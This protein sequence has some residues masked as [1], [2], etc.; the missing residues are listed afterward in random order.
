MSIVTFE[1]VRNNKEVQTY[2]KAGDELLEIIGY[3]KHDFVHALKVADTASYI[4]SELGHDERNIELAKIASYIHDIGNMINRS[5][6]SQ[7]GAVL[8]FHVLRD[9]GMPPEEL[10]IVL[11]AIGNHDEG[12]GS[13]VNI[14]SAALIIADKADVRRSRVRNEDLAT[15]DIHDRVNYAVEKSEVKV[16]V[17]NNIILLDLTIDTKICSL[18]EYFEIFLHRMMLCR[19]A[20][21]FLNY[22]FELDMNGMK[23]L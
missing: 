20:A 18:M 23:I 6:H 11:S 3:T 12:T 5:D 21:D 14:V 8:A 16:D 4:L 13:P 17:A 15:F 9:M 2:I 19:K 1:D 22:K 7:S 10:A